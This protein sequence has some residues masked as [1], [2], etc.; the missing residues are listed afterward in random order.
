MVGLAG[1]AY[2]YGIVMM[3]FDFVGCTF[4]VLIAGV[5]LHAA[6][7]GSRHHDDSRVSGPALQP[8]RADV[9]RRH[10]VAVHGRHRRDDLRQRG[11]DVRRAAR[12]VVLVLGRSDGPLVG[13][14]TTPVG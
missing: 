8:D 12:L 2:R 9:L 6:L 14:F 10:L 7:L 11:G 3:N 13:L 4:A 1:D 5:S